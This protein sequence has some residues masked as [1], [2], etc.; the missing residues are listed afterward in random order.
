MIK[1]LHL[2]ARVIYTVLVTL[3]FSS[4]SGFSFSASFMGIGWVIFLMSFMFQYYVLHF[5]L[6]R[7]AKTPRDRLYILIGWFIVSVAGMLITAYMIPSLTE[8]SQYESDNAF[9]HKVALWGSIFAAFGS[10]FVAM[11]CARRAFT[12]HGGLG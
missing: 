6:K 8:L 9:L 12:R 3:F 5:V 7:S 10:A 11:T 4:I 1:E 2:V